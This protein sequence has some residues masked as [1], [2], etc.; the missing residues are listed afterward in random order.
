MNNARRGFERP[1][2]VTPKASP[3]E[4]L[5]IAVGAANANRTYE[6][7]LSD[8]IV[9][10]EIQVRVGGL[11]AETLA[12][13]IAV[14]ENEGELPA[15]TVFRDD[16]DEHYLAD[17]FHRYRAHVETAKTTI[18]CFVRDGN[19][20]AAIEF[21][22]SANL[23][24]GLKLSNEDKKNILFRRLERG[25]EWKT[26]SARELGRLLGVSR[27]TAGRWIEEYTTVTNVTVDRTQTTGTDGRTYNTTNIGKSPRP[28]RNDGYTPL[29][30]EERAKARP[31]LPEHHSYATLDKGNGEASAILSDE[32]AAR[33]RES[34][35]I[36]A[37][38]QMAQ[39]MGTL[40]NTVSVEILRDID[41]QDRVWLMRSMAFSISDLVR[42]SGQVFDSLPAHLVKEILEHWEKAYVDL[43]RICREMRGFK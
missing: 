5:N 4:A 3:L 9:D 11:D 1:Q 14:L 16:A 15:I 7:F 8:I 21:A 32:I 20:E 42:L 2:L 31:A 30:P 23:E 33:Q 36:H 27:M 41:W 10:E 39:G 26:F 25:H 40:G 12:Q 34:S 24:H 18:K 17:G 13:Y 29:T 28:T 43:E 6:L 35:V 19:R 37:L 22:E 38:E